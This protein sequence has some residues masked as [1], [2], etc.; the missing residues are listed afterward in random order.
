MDEKKTLSLPTPTELIKAATSAHPAFRYATVVVGLAALVWTVYSFGLR[1]ATLV[2]GIIILIFLMALFLVFAAASTLPRPSLAGPATMFVHSVL[3]LAVACAVLLVTSA[4]FGWPLPLRALILAPTGASDTSKLSDDE[5]TALGLALADPEATTRGAWL[6]PLHGELTFR[7]L[8]DVEATTAV[9][10]LLSKGML[11][12]VEVPGTDDFTGKPDKAPALRVTP[13]GV[14][15][16]KSR[17]KPFKAEYFYRL[18]V[19]G[20][21]EHNKPFLDHLGTL[22][23]VE[24]QTRFGRED[25]PKLS[26]IFLYSY[27]PFDQETIANVARMFSV[28]VVGFEEDQ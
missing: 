19:L 27:Q 23:G 24:K 7:G 22:K 20:T 17:L 5:E 2:F 3:F 25:N 4:F 18:T 16:A 10:S 9:N 8:S 11:L 15:Y 1:P 26:M 21:K 28:Q 6:Y 14:D 12:Y 13:R